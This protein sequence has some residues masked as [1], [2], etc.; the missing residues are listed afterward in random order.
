MDRLELLHSKRYE[1]DARA[2]AD[3][4]EAKSPHGIK[5]RLQQVKSAPFD[6]VK[7]LRSLGTFAERYRQVLTMARIRGIPAVGAMARIRT[8]FAGGAR[9][10]R[11][12]VIRQARLRRGAARSPRRRPARRRAA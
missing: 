11:T 5:V 3:E 2:L 8:A 7:A 4:I 12:G 10:R 6:Y 1:K 9:A